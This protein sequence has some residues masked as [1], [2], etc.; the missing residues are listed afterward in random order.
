MYKNLIKRTIE[1]N[2]YQHSQSAKFGDT[3]TG[4]FGWFNCEKSWSR[5]PE[6]LFK[7]LYWNKNLVCIA[8]F[9]NASHFVNDQ[10]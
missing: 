3:L 5:Q 7:D 1:G 4:A 9:E 10:N 2:P 6:M 8:I